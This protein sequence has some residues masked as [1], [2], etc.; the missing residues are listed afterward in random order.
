MFLENFNYSILGTNTSDRIVFVHGLMAFSANWRKIASRME[1]DFQCLIYDQRGH[2]RSFKPEA[3]YSPEVF[4]EDLDKITTEL[5][6]TSF[7]LVGHSMGGRNS[8]VFAYKYPEKVRTLTI[9][10]MGPDADPGINNYYHQMLD[11]VPTPF[12]NKAAVHQFFD[13]EFL[14]KFHPKEPPQVLML[15]LQANLEEKPDGTYDWKFS[16]HAV[17]EI[18]REGH[19]K[20][21]WLEVSSFKMPVLLVRGENSHVLSAETFEKMQQVNPNIQ[22]V[23]IKSVGHWV[24][25]E[26]YQEFIS[27]LRQFINLHNA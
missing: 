16:K 24:H 6:W 13:T 10:D 5:G 14:H 25:F 8:M 19:T 2:G 26:K 12:A 21:R 17:Y 20:D 1:A 23:E 22:G 3:G 27:E 11:S 7:H 18:A 4:A 15:F 9:E